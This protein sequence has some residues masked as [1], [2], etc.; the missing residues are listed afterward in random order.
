MTSF[1]LRDS[2]PKPFIL[3]QDIALRHRPTWRTRRMAWAVHRFSPWMR[4]ILPGVLGEQQL[5]RWMEKIHF[6]K[7]L[8]MM[9]FFVSDI[10][11]S[12]LGD[13]WGMVSRFR[14]YKE[15][16]YLYVYICTL[17]PSVLSTSQV[18]FSVILLKQTEIQRFHCRVPCE[19]I[20]NEMNSPRSKL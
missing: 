9:F 7:D 5:E 6:H 18:F 4:T 8:L 19:K 10:V 12:P 11:K 14:L 17:V 15:Y 3:P 2:R 1:R 16:L 13:T 20:V